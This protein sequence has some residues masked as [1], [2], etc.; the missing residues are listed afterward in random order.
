MLDAPPPVPK[1]INP[2]ARLGRVVLIL[3]AVVV[4][5]LGLVM[6]VCDARLALPPLQQGQTGD[7]PKPDVGLVPPLGNRWGNLH[8]VKDTVTFGR[9]GAKTEGLGWWR[10]QETTGL[11][12]KDIITTKLAGEAALEQ[13]DGV[14]AILAHDAIL[15]VNDAVDPYL[16]SLKQGYL[17]VWTP[18]PLVVETDMTQVTLSASTGVLF[19]VNKEKGKATV[20]VLTGKARVVDAFKAFEPREVTGGQQVQAV[21]NGNTT[22]PVAATHHQDVAY[23]TQQFDSR[24][25]QDKS[26]RRWFTARIGK[27]R[28]SMTE[29]LAP[30]LTGTAP[31]AE[32]SSPAPVPVP[33]AAPPP[34]GPS[35]QAAEM[36]RKEKVAVDAL[37]ALRKATA[38][39]QLQHAGEGPPADPATALAPAMDGG[40][41]QLSLGGGL[42]VEGVA[43]GC[44][45]TCPH[46]TAKEAWLY[47]VSGTTASWRINDRDGMGS[48][49]CQQ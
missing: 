23:L 42:V 47:C 20:E 28:R 25:R 46:P 38:V 34:S 14:K 3:M 31:S 19:V 10:V 40:F 9:A 1:Q 24:V 17:M 30:F 13:Y 33:E 35:P 41:P 7:R 15:Q 6:A 49:L 45:L 18:K 29:R 32:V 27:H 36:A 22:A 8:R 44:P 48:D 5:P 21:L 4:L 12:P 16:W 39:Y 43:V 11:Q 37:M 2:L 26:L